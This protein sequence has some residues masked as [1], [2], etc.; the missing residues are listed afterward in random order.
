[1]F[2]HGWGGVVPD[3][4]L[5]SLSS[6]RSSLAA[7]PMLDQPIDPETAAH[8]EALERD[9]FVIIKNA[10]SEEEADRVKTAISALNRPLGR[11]KFEGL[12]SKRTAGLVGKTSAMD[13]L[14]I[15]PKVV[16]VLDRVL[17]PNYLISLCQ[18]IELQ[19]GEEAQAYHFDDGWF[20]VPRPRK[21]TGVNAFWALDPFTLENG[22][23]H[24]I[25]GSHKWGQDRFP[26]SSKDQVVRAVMPKGSVILFVSTIWHAGGEG[27]WLAR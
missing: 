12:K 13:P 3:F 9:G 17:L 11:N 2:E 1:M 10:I 24:L 19:P 20:R 14:L 23:T 21:P 27:V 4:I 7:D 6:L 18:A 16:N 26:D 15:H 8:L 25:P 5:R 22:A